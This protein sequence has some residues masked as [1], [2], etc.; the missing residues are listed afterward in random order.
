MRTQFGAL[1]RLAVLLCV[2]HCA[3]RR[4]L[5]LLYSDAPAPSCL[6]LQ[7]LGNTAEARMQ[8]L[9]EAAEAGAGAAG[10]EAAAPGIGGLRR[11][12]SALF[13]ISVATGVGA[14]GVAGYYYLNYD[15][16]DLQLIVEETKSQKENAF[17]GSGAWVW[18]ME[19]YLQVRIARGWERTGIGAMSFGHVIYSC[20][21]Q[22]EVSPRSLLVTHAQIGG[23]LRR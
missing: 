13:D 6:V 22:S 3:R 9:K 5:L 18:F 17:I 7:I 16:Q 15:L 4:C 14:A 19:Q 12:M 21:H 20:W 23:N 10:E 2:W 8:Q 1:Y 11:I